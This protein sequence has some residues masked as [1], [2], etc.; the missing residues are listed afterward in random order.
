MK[1]RKC[2]ESKVI[3][4][5]GERYMNRPLLSLCERRLKPQSEEFRGQQREGMR[6]L[7]RGWR[8]T[9]KY[10]EIHSVAVEK[11]SDW[12]TYRQKCSELQILASHYYHYWLFHLRFVLRTRSADL[13]EGY[14]LMQN[15]YTQSARIYRH[16]VSHLSIKENGKYLLIISRFPDCED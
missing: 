4:G 9:E 14:F 5:G 2:Q 1:K 3:L 16:G 6:S 11:I 7:M 8:P 13:H 10:A 12:K 15:T